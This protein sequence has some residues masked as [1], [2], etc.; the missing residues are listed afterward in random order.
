MKRLA[1]AYA[2]QATHRYVT[3][4]TWERRILY[5]Q[6]SLSASRVLHTINF[7]LT[8]KPAASIQGQQ[9]DEYTWK[10]A[11]G[12]TAGVFSLTAATGRPGSENPHPHR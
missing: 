1:G 10:I 3:E 7:H 9:L 8:S 2:N 5:A 6:I 4:V 12:W 11:F